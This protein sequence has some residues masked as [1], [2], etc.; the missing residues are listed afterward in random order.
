YDIDDTHPHYQRLKEIEQQV[1]SGAGLTK[2]L[3][4]YARKGRYEIKTID[5]NE[6][7]KQTS[8]AFGRTRKEIRVH[9][10]LA[11]GLF[12]M[13]A[14]QGQIEQ[15]LL[16]LYVNAADAMPAGGDLI[17]KTMNVTHEDMKGKLYSPKPGNYVLSTVTDTGMGMDQ[18]AQERIFEPFFTTKDLD[19]GTGLGLACVYGIVKGH[20]GYID[21]ES[22]KGSGTTVSIYLP[23]TEKK[24]EKT[25]KASE[26]VIAGSETILFVDDEDFVLKVGGG[27][28]E[29]LGYTVFK[30][31]GGREAVEIYETKKDEIDL[32]VLDMI[33]PDMGGGEAYDRIKE[34]NP[35]V[36]VLLSS[37]YSIDSQA[38]EILSR[39]CNGFIQ[40]P[41]TMKELS[42]K[43]REILDEK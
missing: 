41:F 7:V 2:Q 13:E 23:A 37:G 34:F 25:V 43:I 18:D 30:A 19:R 29:R 31:V 15:V 6:L 14:D 12:A 8:K 42:L 21:V 26:Q 36:K 9:R 24:A 35:D 4:G 33:M 5:L 39:G 32:V 22:E 20:A 27:L 17:L 40:K 3:L 38:K 1:R 10:E 16:N 28:L 11:K